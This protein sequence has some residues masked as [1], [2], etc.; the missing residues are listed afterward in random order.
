MN[1]TLYISTLPLLLFFVFSR[2]LGRMGVSSYSNLGRVQKR[3]DLEAVF[4]GLVGHSTA[5][6]RGTNY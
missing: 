3:V 1:K 4:P 2:V 6:A 5:W